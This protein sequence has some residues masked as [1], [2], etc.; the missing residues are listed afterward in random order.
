M[1]DDFDFDTDFGTT[2]TVELRLTTEIAKL[3]YDLQ[4]TERVLADLR[5]VKRMT[6]MS[7]LKEYR[8]TLHILNAVLRE[9]GLSLETTN[10][11][12]LAIRDRK[13]FIA[14]LD[15]KYTRRN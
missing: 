7:V 14:K 5:K 8:D 13:A 2:D 4:E 3:K 1:Q 9:T 10:T 12:E 15:A 6:S 11:V